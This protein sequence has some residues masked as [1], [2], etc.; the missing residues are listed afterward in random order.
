[1]VHLTASDISLPSEDMAAAR[2]ERERERGGRQRL[3][4]PPL[5]CPTH[6]Q[7]A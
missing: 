2:R 7:S 1:M 5:I 6:I 4:G 3:G